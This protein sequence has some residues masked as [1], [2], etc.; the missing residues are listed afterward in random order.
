V[1]IVNYG[2]LWPTPEEKQVAAIAAKYGR[3]SSG[4]RELC[5]QWLY[6]EAAHD[7]TDRADYGGALRKPLDVESWPAL[8][9]CELG[10]GVGGD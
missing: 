4:L 1:R 3:R 9:F 5:Y 2:K 7:R 6:L 10:T 8:D